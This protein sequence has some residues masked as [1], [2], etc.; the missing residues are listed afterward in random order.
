MA[1]PRVDTISFDDVNKYTIPVQGF[2]NGLGIPYL[3]SNRN[4]DDLKNRLCDS[5]LCK[6]SEALMTIPIIIN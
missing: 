5:F 4:I 2:G 6:P 3:D 1:Y